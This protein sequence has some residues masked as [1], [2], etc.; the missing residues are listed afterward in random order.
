MPDR[1]LF[2]V[3]QLNF[4]AIETTAGTFPSHKFIQSLDDVA[5]RDLLVAAQILASTIAIG[6]PPAGRSERVRGSNE[7]LYELRITPRGRHGVHARLLYVRVGNDIRCVRGSLKRE[8]LSHDDIKLA[9]RDLRAD[10]RK[11]RK[12]RA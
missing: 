5:K 12:P 2:N 10:A 7:S 8:R 11:Q 9:D 1:F 6:R 4:Y 3:E